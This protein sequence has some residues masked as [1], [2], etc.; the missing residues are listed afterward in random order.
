MWGFTCYSIVITSK[1]NC[2]IFIHLDPPSLVPFLT[3][4]QALHT[5]CNKNN[6]NR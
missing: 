6:S 4:E 5:F 3:L 2:N 1:P